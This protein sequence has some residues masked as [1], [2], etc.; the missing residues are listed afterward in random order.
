MG[1]HTNYV[2]IAALTAISAAAVVLSLLRGRGTPRKKL[3]RSVLL[4]GGATLICF[5]GEAMLAQFDM[6]WRCTPFNIMLFLCAVLFVIVLW[7]CMN[8]LSLL[9]NT[10][11]TLR[12]SI[13]LF[14]TPVLVITLAWTAAYFCLL[15][16]QDDLA[17]YNEQMIV[18]AN[19]MH[20]GSGSWRYYVHINN[21]VHGAEIAHDG[22][23]W[24]IPPFQ[25]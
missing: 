23:W 11:S 13:F 9:E 19:D 24:G 1:S 17:P 10:H 8:V 5:G 21:L 18:C 2:F 15:S 12:A 3:L 14:L 7:H 16:W 6:G 25:P 22:S 20:G 4:L